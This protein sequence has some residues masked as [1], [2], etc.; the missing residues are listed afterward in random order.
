MCMCVCVSQMTTP[1]IMKNLTRTGVRS[2]L[3][4][5]RLCSLPMRMRTQHAAVYV[6]SSQHAAL[7]SMRQQEVHDAGG[8]CLQS[9]CVAAENAALDA[10]MPS[11][12]VSVPS[13]QVRMEIAGM[14]GKV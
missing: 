13:L 6:L 10:G 8:L 4:T 12:V 5:L 14:R 9:A 11:Q 7:M 1:L 3:W 2:P